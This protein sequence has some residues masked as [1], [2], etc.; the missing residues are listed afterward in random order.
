MGETTKIK[1][2][3]NIVL[4][5]AILDAFL[6]VPLVYG[7]ITDSEV[8]KQILGPIHGI[9]FLILV[10]LTGRG[11]VEKLW[12]WWFPVIVVLTGGPPGSIVGDIVVRSQLRG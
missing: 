1:R 6:L 11:A 2:Q 5:V 4:V 9:G 10:F 12:G 7:F 8:H 3:L